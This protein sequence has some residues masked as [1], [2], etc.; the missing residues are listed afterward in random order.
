MQPECD[1]EIANEYSTG[2]KK[3]SRFNFYDLETESMG[4]V[5][6]INSK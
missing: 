4:R 5:I 2:H 3:S 1:I 6:P